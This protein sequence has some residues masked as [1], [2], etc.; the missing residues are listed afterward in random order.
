M[1]PNM[2]PMPTPIGDIQFRHYGG[3]SDFVGMAAM[4][5]AQAAAD[6]LDRQVSVDQMANTYRNASNCDLDTDLVIAERQGV[7]VGY[8][9]VTWWIEAE[10]N[11]RILAHVGWGHPDVREFGLDAALITWGERRLLDIAAASPHPGGDVL[12]TSAAEPEAHKRQVLAAA[13]YRITQTHAR[14]VRS[15]A[16]PIEDHPLPSGLL[17]KPVTERDRRRVWEADVEAFRDHIGYAPPTEADY[18]EFLGRPHFDPALWKVAFDG[19]AIAGQVLNFIDPSENDGASRT[20]GWT[21]WI[22]TQ[23]QW[24]GRG[25]AKALITESLRM[26]RD[27]GLDEA[28]LGVHTTNPH[29]AFQL[30]SGLGYEVIETAYE[31]RKELGS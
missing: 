8:C 11:R 28:A 19:D 29:G 22:S 30:Y 27:M 15:L 23:R 16:D 24:R 31:L 26:L 2:T 12:Q 21:E 18:Q 13:G 1:N 3:E 14:M 9:R 5:T 10:S 7:I 20:R 25:V 4:L 6:G 17:I